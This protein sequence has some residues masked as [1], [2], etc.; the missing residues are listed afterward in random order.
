MAIAFLIGRIVFGA[1]WLHAAYGHLV[2][3]GGM[4]GYAQSKG[5]KSPKLA[6]VGT[7]LLALLGGLSILL[8]AWPV[9]G[10]A[11]LVIF[12]VGVSFKMHAFW[13]ATDPMAKMGDSINFWKNMALVGALL[14][15]L[16]IPQPWLYSL[17]W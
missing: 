1:Y 2:H 15:F 3:P 4:V 14:M 5:V 7:G 8:G 12:L 17:G 16:A 11:L 6:I 9:V 13:S 10:V